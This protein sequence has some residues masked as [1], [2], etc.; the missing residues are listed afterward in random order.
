MDQV[1]GV[2]TFIGYTVDFVDAKLD[3]QLLVDQTG[4]ASEEIRQLQPQ[5]PLFK[6]LLEKNKGEA[7]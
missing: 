6:R 5:F 4:N 1:N 3:G 7:K 2:L